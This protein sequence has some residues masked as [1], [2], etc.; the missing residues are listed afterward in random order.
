MNLFIKYPN[1]TIMNNQITDYL[2]TYCRLG[3]GRIGYKG[4]CWHCGAEVENINATIPNKNALAI[5]PA[6]SGCQI[7]EHFG[8]GNQK[9]LK[10]AAS[11]D[12]TIATPLTKFWNC[13]ALRFSVLNF[14]VM[15]NLPCACKKFK[16]W[17]F[18]QEISTLIHNL[19]HVTQQYELNLNKL[20][21]LVNAMMLHA[22][23]CDSLK[24]LL[25]TSTKKK[26]SFQAREINAWKIKYTDGIQD[27]TENLILRVQSGGTDYADVQQGLFDYAREPHDCNVQEGMETTWDSV[28]QTNLEELELL[29]TTQFKIDE[30]R[31]QLV[32]LKQRTLPLKTVPDFHSNLHESHLY[33]EL[34]N[35]ALN[36]PAANNF[37]ENT[38]LADVNQD[39][40]QA[41]L[42]SIL[43]I[44]TVPGSI[45]LVV[46]MDV[47]NN[48]KLL[49]LSGKL[50]EGFRAMRL[51]FANELIIP[52][53]KGTKFIVDRENIEVFANEKG[54]LSVKI[55]VV[56]FRRDGENHFQN[57]H[58][59]DCDCINQ[60]KSAKGIKWLLITALKHSMNP[61]HEANLLESF[62]LFKDVQNIPTL[63]SDIDRLIHGKVL[64]TKIGYDTF[65]ALL[66]KVLFGSVNPAV[67][68]GL[69][70]ATHQLLQTKDNQ[71]RNKESYFGNVMSLA[72]YSLDMLGHGRDHRIE[73]GATQVLSLLSTWRQLHHLTASDMALQKYRNLLIATK[74]IESYET[75][76]QDLLINVFD[77][78]TKSASSVGKKALRKSKIASIIHE[79]LEVYLLNVRTQQDADTRYVLT[80]AYSLL[81]TI[82][83]GSRKER[84]L[85]S[86]IDK[87]VKRWVHGNSFEELIAIHVPINTA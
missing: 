18:D 31:T 45:V 70:R 15:E 32:D 36:P 49:Q 73:L 24:D 61:P 23:Q 9:R 83:E 2:W 85:K 44:E 52:E 37:S 56:K 80:T 43:T 39:S 28:P 22:E 59:G 30:L 17:D 66:Y 48:E 51:R 46:S 64:L 13:S 42:D 5:C 4:L 25:K 41:F 50:Q 3:N 16:V 55:R 47:K 60:E 84:R 11:S 53:T 10:E 8:D 38:L 20:Y 79:Y 72:N 69:G 82:Y 33:L 34:A 7:W 65:A 71:N 86:R 35:L 12:G 40:F 29:F 81:L 54:G 6:K 76:R 75:T 63:L 26:T 1:N 58:I 19:K 68:K 74:R 67:W 78:V 57:I 62:G 27:E 77:I 14:Y 87:Y 21:V